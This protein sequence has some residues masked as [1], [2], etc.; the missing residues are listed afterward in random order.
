MSSS[1]KEFTMTTVNLSNN[2][3]LFDGAR[4]T[5]QKIKE[6]ISHIVVS[7]DSY[8]YWVTVKWLSGMYAANMALAKALQDMKKFA[9]QL[10]K[11]EP[12]IFQDSSPEAKDK[13]FELAGKYDDYQSFDM[14]G[15][16]DE[17]YKQFCI[18][19]R[20]YKNKQFRDEYCISIAK[21]L[22]LIAA[23][24]KFSEQS[25]DAIKEL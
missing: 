7:G 4:E 24:D 21:M 5:M 17:F 2:A 16:Y 9:I 22:A 8:N 13:I 23:I 3:T 18:C 25:V 15:W 14:I 12:E 20:E 11:L 10:A 19:E 1:Q 6:A